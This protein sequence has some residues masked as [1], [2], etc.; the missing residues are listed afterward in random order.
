M[1]RTIFLPD[2]LRWVGGINLS[3]VLGGGVT[4][5]F[6]TLGLHGMVHVKLVL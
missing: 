4:T 6:R 1:C 3:I 2:L 5:K